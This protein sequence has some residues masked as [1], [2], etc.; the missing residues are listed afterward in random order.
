MSFVLN[1]LGLLLASSIVLN[2]KRTAQ[3]SSSESNILLS[4]DVKQ[5]LRIAEHSV[6]GVGAS[7]SYRV[8]VLEPDSLTASRNERPLAAFDTTIEAY[9]TGLTLYHENG[10]AVIL[11]S[12]H[13]L[14]APDTIITYMRTAEGKET[15]IPET[16]AIKVG[17]TH[18]I[19]ADGAPLRRAEVLCTDERSDL[20]MV[21]AAMP[22]PSGLAFPFTIAYDRDLRWGDVVFL[23]GYPR[24]TK[25]VTFGLVSPSR[26]PGNFVI[27]AVTRFGYSGGPILLPEEDGSLQLVGIVRAMAAEEIQ[28][29]VPPL[30]VTPGRRLLPDDLTRLRVQRMYM[31]DYGITYGI[32]VE[33]VGTF[34][35][36]CRDQL[37]RRGIELSSK[38]FPHR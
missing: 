1:I 16:R 14:H 29:V 34:L 25:Q 33:R 18:F 31:I 9:G 13:L 4:A 2:C 12:Q 21:L 6:V 24:Q 26:Y 7:Y 22:L 10:Q 3:R 5:L 11:T 35:I 27:D 15:T 19:D 36:Q 8:E 37:H 38:V 23:F 32:G 30:G 17:A 20:G 28:F